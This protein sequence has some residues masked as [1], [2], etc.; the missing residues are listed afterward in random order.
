MIKVAFSCV[1][2]VTALFIFTYNHRCYKTHYWYNDCPKGA[3]Y[4]VIYRDP[5]AAFYSNFNYLQGWFF[6]PG[7]VTIEDF[8]SGF[9]H[10]SGKAKNEMVNVPYNEHLLSWWEHRNDPNVLFLFFEEMKQDLESVVKVVASFMG[11]NDKEKIQTAVQMSSFEF[12]KA[13]GTKFDENLLFLYRNKACG[14]PEDA[15]GNKIASG[16]NSIALRILPEKVK[17]KIE[18]KWRETVTATFGFQTYDELRIAF[19]KENP[20]VK[21]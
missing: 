1:R 9:D 13:S 14:L 17:E 7:E 5:C 12:M 16:S 6:R 18:K 2:A 10:T 11:I 3:K 4:I 20:L 21:H 8:A 15:K 19:R